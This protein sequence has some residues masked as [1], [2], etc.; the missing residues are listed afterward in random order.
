[1]RCGGWLGIW[2]AA[3]VA[4]ALY[5]RATSSH[6]GSL[7]RCSLDGQTLA[8]IHQVYQVDLM[9]EGR[10]VAS[11]CCVACARDWPE[12]RAGDWW[13]VRDE[14]TGGPLDAAC[15]CFVESRIVSNAARGCRLHAFRDW[16][17][18]AGHADE[19]QGK[20]VDNPLALAGKTE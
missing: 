11:F 2:F 3:V 7:G 17:V 1:M 20:R 4:L 13:Q 15:A 12:V 8:P 19:F 5:G 16:T 14:L 9:R 10:P 18:A 6:A